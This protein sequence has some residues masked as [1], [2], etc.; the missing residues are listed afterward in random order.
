[1]CRNA[2]SQVRICGSFFDDF[3]VQAGLHQGSIL[4]PMLFLAADFAVGSESFDGWEYRQESW[5]GVLEPK[6]WE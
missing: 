2:Q 3:L 6:G 5:K 1:M 4:S